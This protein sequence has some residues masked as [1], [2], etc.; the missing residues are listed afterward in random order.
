MYDLPEYI[1]RTDRHDLAQKLGKLEDIEEKMGI[2]LLIWLKAKQSGIYVIN[3]CG[4]KRYTPLAPT[5]NLPSNGILL[6]Q[7][8][9]FVNVKDYGKKKV[10]GWA[11]TEEE[12]EEGK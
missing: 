8:M 7:F 11:L 2:D 5:C 6:T 1:D 12:L 3:N 9:G 10:G 4:E